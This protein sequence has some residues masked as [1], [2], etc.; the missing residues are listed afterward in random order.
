[1]FTSVAG[2][3]VIVTGGT[4][5]IGKGIARVF[6]RAGANV[7]VTGRDGLRELRLSFRNNRSSRGELRIQIGMLNRGNHLARG[8]ACSLF[9]RERLE[10]SARF[11]SDVT[12][13]PR[14]H[15]A[16]R[17]EDR[18]CRRPAR[19]GLK[20]G[21][22]NRVHFGRAPLGPILARRGI[23]HRP[24]NRQQDDEEPWPHA[25]SRRRAIDAQP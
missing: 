11:H 8:D 15:V 13:S 24:T 10:A 4:R 7:L 21:G 18:Q 2:R 3:S 9:E 23:A 16:G 6:V 5:G 19:R 22:A 17:D 14:D 20:L 1:M 12:A 25:S